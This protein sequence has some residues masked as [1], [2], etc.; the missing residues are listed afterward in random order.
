MKYFI[1][2]DVHG[3][4]YSLKTALDEAGFD[5]ENKDHTLV[6]LGDN[7]DRGG[8]SKGVFKFLTTLPRA[9]CLKGN[10][11]LILEEVFDR[12]HLTNLDIYNG[13]LSTVASFAG[14][15]KTMVCY[16]QEEAVEMASHYPKL[17]QW[18]LSRPYYFETKNYI[19][20]HGWLPRSYYDDN[21][22]A[23]ISAADWKEATWCN[24]EDEIINHRQ[25]VSANGVDSY[26]TVVIGHWHTYRLRERFDNIVVKKAEK[27]NH[28]IWADDKYK[29][30][31]VDG[32]T[33]TSKEVN[34]LVV[35]DEP[36]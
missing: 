10:H 32:C 34:V 19:F 22:L 23:N 28:S 7:F 33:P 13:A 24:T 9:I 5:R 8:L 27:K 30:I 2:G 1:V 3:C 4:L 35:E 18:L 20:T 15:S 11:E 31:A 14:M 17:A 26:K 25:Q 12:G 36:V 29:I 6:S 16:M 21:R